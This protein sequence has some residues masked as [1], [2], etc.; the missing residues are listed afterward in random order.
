MY[1]HL[2]SDLIL[3][4]TG[5]FV[6]VK[7]FDLV[8]VSERVFWSFFILTTLFLAIIEIFQILKIGEWA[9]IQHFLQNLRAVA[10]GVGLIVGAW[11]LV[12][13]TNF[14]PIVSLSIIGVV[15]TLFVAV[16][17]FQSGIMSI[18]FL[19]FCII[20]V[21]MIACWG[22]LR[23]QRSGLWLVFAMMFLALSLKKTSIQVEMGQVEI[24]HYLTSLSILFLGYAIQNRSVI[25]FR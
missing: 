18:I 12:S 22:L 9:W 2:L 10:G 4:F 23:R 17:N 14:K 7:C 5:I 25:L 11:C 6:V 19:P 1:L 8:N 3:I 13:N 21:L 20:F 16:I 24:N 15:M